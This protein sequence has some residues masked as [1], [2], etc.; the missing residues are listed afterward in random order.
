MFTSSVLQL[1]FG[2]LSDR[3]HSRQ[4]TVLSPLVAALFLTA[5]GLAP[6]FGALIVLLLIGGIAVA[7]FHPHSTSQAGRLAGDRRG[8]ATAVFITA[9]TAGLGFGPLYLAGVIERFGFERLWLAALPAIVAAPVLLWRMPQPVGSEHT[10]RQ[11]VDWNA[12]AGHAQSLLAHY[13]LVVLR[14]VVQVG[15]GQFLSLYMVRVRGLD[16]RGAS[17]ALAVFLLSTPVG[18]FLGGAASDRYGGR[19]VILCS[20]IGSVPMLAAFL[21]LEGWL[22]LLALFCGGVVLLTT[23]PVHVVMAQELTPT[24]AGTTTA[25]M[26]GFGWGIA[27]IVFV[28]IAGWLADD[29]GLKA[30]LGGMAL[31]PILGFPIAL[32]LPRAAIQR[33]ASQ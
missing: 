26:M 29:V 21:A 14:S 24:Q 3:L 12:L 1:P 10:K 16:L 8:I 11:G 23:I 25:L 22:S 31:L 7:A 9:G 13:T 18:S 2:L 6:N 15:W 27:G 19:R 32:T 5:M 4:F 17:M 33:R 20:C 28:P 30:V